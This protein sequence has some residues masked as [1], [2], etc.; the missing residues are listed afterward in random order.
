MWGTTGSPPLK[1]SLSRGTRSSRWPAIPLRPRFSTRPTGIDTLPIST[2]LHETGEP[3]GRLLMSS[4]G[5]RIGR[6]ALRSPADRPTG[7]AT[8][9]DRHGPD[10]ELMAAAAA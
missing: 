5:D 3:Q 10:A 8:D 1:R 2:A 9:H 4:G 7:P 6:P